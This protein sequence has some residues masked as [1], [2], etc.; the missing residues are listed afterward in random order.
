MEQSL[1]N[2]MHRTEASQIKPFLLDLPS[3]QPCVFSRL[4]IQPSFASAQVL[5]I[6][7]SS[8]KFP[9]KG[10]QVNSV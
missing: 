1:L 9:K 4:I 3:T 7:K 5:K 6:H 8:D 2:I 10:K